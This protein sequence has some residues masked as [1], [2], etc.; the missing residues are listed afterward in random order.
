MF[1]H[2]FAGTCELGQTVT[3]NRTVLL[4]LKYI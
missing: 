4:N 2:M 1:L 3:V